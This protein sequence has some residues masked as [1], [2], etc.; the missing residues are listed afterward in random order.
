MADRNAIEQLFADYGWP[1]DTREWPVLA[2]VFTQDA[3]F[4]ITIQG[5]EAVSVTGCDAI[6][7][8]CSSTVNA[9]TDQR[10]HVIT[11]VRITDATD[12]T[13]SVYAILTLVVVT[14]VLEVKSS[15]LYRT[16]VVREADGQWR[17]AQMLLELDRTF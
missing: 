8:F 13:A 12:T 2:T 9:Q 6:V 14:D 5:E 3:S 4:V 11:N 16:R 10:R 17:F 7:E 1:M 15:G